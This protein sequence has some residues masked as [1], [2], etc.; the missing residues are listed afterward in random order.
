MSANAPAASEFGLVG[1]L[2]GRPAVAPPS[3]A[4]PPP[5]AP[6]P[7]AAAPAAASAPELAPAAPGAPASAPSSSAP[8]RP[9]VVHDAS[10]A[11]AGAGGDFG[12]DGD[13][14]LA[15]ASSGAAAAA[16]A[17]SSGPPAAAARSMSLLGSGGKGKWKSVKR[18]VRMMTFIERVGKMAAYARPS[19]LKELSLKPEHAY[20]AAIVPHVASDASGVVDCGATRPIAPAPS[21]LCTFTRAL[22]VPSAEV[23]R[24]IARVLVR[25]CL[26]DADA[27]AFVGNVASVP[28]REATD[29]QGVAAWKFPEAVAGDPSLG[30]FHLAIRA[31]DV[32]APQLHVEL[33][34][35]PAATPEEAAASSAGALGPVRGDP[36]YIARRAKG[37]E[38]G[39][40]SEV[41]EI[42][43]AWGR[44]ALPAPGD[45][46]SGVASVDVPLSGAGH[47]DPMTI[48]SSPLAKERAGSFFRKF[49]AK[50]RLLAKGP[51]V[52]V[53]FTAVK[54]EAAANVARLPRGPLVLPRAFVPLVAVYR[55]LCAAE[56]TES[57]NAAGG[58]KEN[59][60]ALPEGGNAGVSSR[61]SLHANSCHPTLRALPSLLAWPLVAETLAETHH[62][63][64]SR[65]SA[66]QWRDAKRA[67]ETLEGLVL[68]FWPLLFARAVPELGVAGDAEGIA[69]AEAIV[70][71]YA[72]EHP[73]VAM[74]R[75]PDEWMHAPLDVA[76]LAHN[77]ADG[78]DAY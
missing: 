33:C 42:C 27:G 14:G 34:V 75:D 11:S 67:A 54:P 57:T 19:K 74:S 72:D 73:V 37:G 40:S 45:F 50:G 39:G 15:G 63:M 62:R 26:W 8:L 51:T 61:D 53:K 7:A 9:T 49:T 22:D 12:L 71:R 55:D 16:P 35:V 32:R 69:R 18:A 70:R 1:D 17:G 78:H 56:A 76:E 20:P 68:K 38:G 24:K 5:A 6:P 23:D 52:S 64:T 25:V 43:C 58:D 77:F 44:V 10:K 46:K 29:A 66:S 21:A 28:A 41:D 4:S 47:D 59:A 30:Q 3:A 65:W 31:G 36:G 60:G 2:T 48:E 13:L